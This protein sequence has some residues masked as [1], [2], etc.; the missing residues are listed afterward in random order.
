LTSEGVER[1]KR[2]RAT[3]REVLQTRSA[4]RI[5]R[6]FNQQIGA[7]QASVARLTSMAE[8]ARAY[9]RY[10]PSQAVEL[11]ALEHMIA[12]HTARFTAAAS[13]LPEDVR[14][15]ARVTDTRR[16]L[17]SLAAAAER[18]HL[19][20][21]GGMPDRASPD[22]RSPAGRDAPI[23]GL[24]RWGLRLARA[25]KPTGRIAAP[26]RAPAWEN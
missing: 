15:N 3:N 16:A 1:E 14:N 13:M 26:R 11:E 24:S 10:A 8:R 20:L 18:A 5:V 23:D 12:V 19:L 2:R 25:P 7:W 9:G 4:L 22:E 17:E 21:E 6:P